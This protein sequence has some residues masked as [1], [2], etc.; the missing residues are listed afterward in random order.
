MSSFFIYKFLRVAWT[1]PLYL[2][3]M[4]STK[5]DLSFF[6]RPTS[7][8]LPVNTSV[9]NWS[10]DTI[11]L[12]IL[13]SPTSTLQ[14]LF[15]SGGFR[16]NVP[17][18]YPRS[19][20]R[21]NPCSCEMALA[22]ISNGVVDLGIHWRVRKLLRYFSRDNP[23]L[24]CVRSSQVPGHDKLRRLIT[25]WVVHPQLVEVQSGTDSCPCFMPL[26]CYLT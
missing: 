6:G 25:N 9:L 20:F 26:E 5:S 16:R 14:V 3:A 12:I 21:S 4:M 17:C 18:I 11:G 22:V 19:W 2:F 23:L 24:Q 15:T 10:L 1:F 7:L 13:Q 8:H